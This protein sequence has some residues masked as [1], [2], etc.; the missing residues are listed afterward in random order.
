MDDERLVA[1]WVGILSSFLVFLAVEKSQYFLGWVLQAM[2][3]GGAV[4]IFVRNLRSAVDANVALT[5]SLMT[6]VFAAAAIALCLP[7]LFQD[8]TQKA[9]LAVM[10]CLSLTSAFI[11]RPAL[12][13]LSDMKKLR[14]QRA[15]AAA[16]T[17][18]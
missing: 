5:A 1:C 13:D 10:L 12:K 18:V 8:T 11:L 7:N 3:I 2:L 17:T 9:L 16:G 4:A 14:P 15:A 6:L